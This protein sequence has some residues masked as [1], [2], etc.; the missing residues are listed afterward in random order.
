LNF[1]PGAS[2][3]TLTAAPVTRQGAAMLRPTLIVSALCMLALPT[4][5][6][7]ASINDLAWLGGCWKIP[8]SEAGSEEHWM[9]PAGGAM[10]GMD[11][12]ITGSKL[13]A[14]EFMRIHQEGD[15][16]I[17]T[18]KPS[19]KPE[20]SFELISYDN[21]R[22]VFENPQKDFPQRVIYQHKEDGSLLARIEGKAANGLDKA[23]EFP[24][25]RVGCGQ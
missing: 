16:L 14:F 13:S 9:A 19:S 11:R 2:T 24:M 22:A 4:A 12:T 15:K 3:I 5:S 21:K 8:G 18:A 1:Q 7:A 6:L 25:Q 23:I 20:A 10:L 17:F